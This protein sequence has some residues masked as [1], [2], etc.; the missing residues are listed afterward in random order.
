MRHDIIPTFLGCILGRL[1]SLQQRPW[2]MLQSELSLHSSPATP[3]TQ[4]SR[5]THGN[6]GSFKDHLRIILF[7]KIF[8]ISGKRSQGRLKCLTELA[9]PR[10]GFT[11]G[12]V[13]T[14]VASLAVRVLVAVL[15]GLLSEHGQATASHWGKQDY[16]SL[17]GNICP[18]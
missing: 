4:L 10:C 2:W 14:D 3:V 11:A 17:T 16:L 1:V 15:A 18:N 13:H 12:V 7:L 8:L 6:V 5:G 9:Q